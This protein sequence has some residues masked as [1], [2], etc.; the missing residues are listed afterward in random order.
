[1]Y[2]SLI[3]TNKKYGFIYNKKYY[4]NKMYNSFLIY[5]HLQK[6]WFYIQQKILHQ[7]NVG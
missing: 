2:D 5:V 3:Y 4:T 1:M 6:I 7:Q